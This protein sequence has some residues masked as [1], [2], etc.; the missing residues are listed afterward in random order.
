MKG[1]IGVS[2]DRAGLFVQCGLPDGET[3]WV[4]DVD[5]RLAVLERDWVF[6]LR[7]LVGGVDRGAICDRCGPLASYIV[8]LLGPQRRLL[9]ILFIF[10]AE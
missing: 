2:S 7:I 6:I 5:E 1:L 10:L 4:L 8:A 3:E 9:W